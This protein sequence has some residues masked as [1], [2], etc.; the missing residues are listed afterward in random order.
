MVLQQEAVMRVWKNCACAWI[1]SYVRKL[2][3]GSNTDSRCMPKLGLQAFESLDSCASKA[4]PNRE[5]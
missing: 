1:R 3:V 4:L 2:T 5:P